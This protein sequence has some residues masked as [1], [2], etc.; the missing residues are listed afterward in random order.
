MQT[1]ALSGGCGVFVNWFVLRRNN[2][3]NMFEMWLYDQFSTRAMIL[4]DLK[5]KILLRLVCWDSAL[6][7]KRILHLKY[8]NIKLSPSG[9]WELDSLKLLLWLYL[10]F[11]KRVLTECGSL[12]AAVWETKPGLLKW[13]KGR[14]R[15][16]SR[17]E[18]YCKMTNKQY[19]PGQHCRTCLRNI[20]FTSVS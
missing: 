6:R 18:I 20:V 4:L 10:C 5:T 19:E 14:Q 11:I 2:F 15:S 13:F 1:L 16:A 7:L 8:F 9:I 17:P 12:T 3:K